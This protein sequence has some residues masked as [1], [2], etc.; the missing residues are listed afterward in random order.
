MT[1]LDPLL[2]P[3]WAKSLGGE[4]APVPLPPFDL[5]SGISVLMEGYGDRASCYSFVPR[6]GVA[7]GSTSFLNWGFRYCASSGEMPKS[8][9]FLALIWEARI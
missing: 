4:L 3:G 2:R 8:T 1:C 9:A 7:C 5:V 6:W